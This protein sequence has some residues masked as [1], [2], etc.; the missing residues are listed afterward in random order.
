MERKNT[1]VQLD[2]VTLQAIE[3][4]GDFSDVD[5]AV[6]LGLLTETQRDEVYS[7]VKKI[8]GSIVENMIYNTLG[9]INS[10]NPYQK[11]GSNYYF[12]LNKTYEIYYKQKRTQWAPATRKNIEYVL[13][14][15][16]KFIYDNGELSD[17]T[18]ELVLFN[19]EIVDD[20]L[21]HQFELVELNKRSKYTVKSQTKS[22]KAFVNWI[23]TTYNL[24]SIEI[25][26]S[27]IDNPIHDL[28]SIEEL[29][30]LIALP[31]DK[32]FHAVRNHAIIA[33]LIGTGCRRRSLQ[34]IKVK[35]IHFNSNR[36]IFNVAKGDRPYEVPL[37]TSLYETL[38][39]YINKF[40]LQENDYL[41]CGESRQQLS[42]DYL[43]KLVSRY[44]T[45]HGVEKTSIHLFRHT[46]AYNYLRKNGDVFSLK[47]LL[48]HSTLDMVQNYANMN[49]LEAIKVNYDEK[50]LLD[51]I[52]TK[53]KKIHRR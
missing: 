17:V 52:S 4:L 35:D 10:R 15:F 18:G 47:T 49:N 50:N 14:P 33:F 41:F 8:T 16:I 7:Q 38:N 44:N 37:S 43:T 31:T 13:K 19:Q 11:W 1:K 36:I 46:Y 53:K 34:N 25:K 28:Y 27:K 30:K 12:N 20:W 45:A 40:D 21:F 51:A 24:P 32:S 5:N 9:C 39:N 29:K 2:E 42:N 26:I 3:T 22:V 48:N 23:T 6:E